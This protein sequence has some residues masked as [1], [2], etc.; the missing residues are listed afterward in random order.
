MN[1]GEAVALAT[2]VTVVALDLI[3]TAGAFTDERLIEA[4]PSSGWHNSEVCE[5]LDELAKRGVIAGGF[6]PGTERRVWLGLKP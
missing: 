6:L 2:Q 5:V 1:A 3:R 4:L